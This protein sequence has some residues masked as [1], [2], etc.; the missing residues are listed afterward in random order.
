[1]SVLSPK[2]GKSNYLENNVELIGTK[3]KIE[4]EHFIKLLEMISLKM[5]P[6]LNAE[7]ALNRII[8]ENILRFNCF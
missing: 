7:K 4:F 1:M 6:E 5:W 3:G 8:E 2:I